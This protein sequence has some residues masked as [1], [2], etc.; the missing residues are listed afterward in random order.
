MLFVVISLFKMPLSVVL[1]SCLV[2]LSTRRLGCALQ[3]KYVLRELS[4]SMS[5]SAVGCEL[6]V[7]E[8]TIYINKQKHTENKIRY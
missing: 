2:F 1:K 6:N 3:R 5:Y 8:S 4:S 7:N